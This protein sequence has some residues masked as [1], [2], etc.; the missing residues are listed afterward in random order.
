[1]LP[2]TDW[3]SHGAVANVKGGMRCCVVVRSLRPGNVDRMSD[4]KGRIFYRVEGVGTRGSGK[5]SIREGM[6]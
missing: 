6:R 3:P 5:N 2:S 1:M 4:R